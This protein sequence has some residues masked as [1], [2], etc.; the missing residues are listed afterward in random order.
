MTP[1][2]L[3]ERIVADDELIIRRW[4]STDARVMHA[5]ISENLEHLRP[6]MAWARTEPLSIDARLRLF[7]KWDR[8]WASGAGAVYA[9][10]TGCEIVGGCS[11]HRRVGPG[12]IDLGYWL[13]RSGTGQ[14][15]ATRTGRALTEASFTLDLDIG[16]VQ[17]SHR[18]S[19][20]ASGAVAERLGYVNI[21]A[22]DEHTVT[23][24]QH[25]RRG[26]PAVPPHDSITK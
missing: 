5:L 13:G 14:G 18:A 3:P 22:E 1:P 6:W 25:G 11:L 4:D 9:I 16:F 23:T 26:R 2:Q 15:I 8:Y 12:G 24:W 7:E 20:S 21:T 17:I 10:E 19:N